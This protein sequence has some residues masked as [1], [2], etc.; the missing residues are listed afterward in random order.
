[1]LLKRVK[2]RIKEFCTNPYS[3]IFTVML[4]LLLFLIVVPLW[5]ILKE[6]LELS[7][8]DAKREGLE[9]GTLSFYY[10]KKLFCSVISQKM[11][12]QPL[13]HSLVIAICVSVISITIG[14]VAAWLMVRTDLPFK[15]FF[16][17]AI[18]VPY[19][20]PA[21]CKA[22]AWIAV[23]KN[24]RIGGAAGFLSYLGFQV[25]DW[26]AYGPVVMTI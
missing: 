1:M 23:F 18:I 16:T 26:L 17:L 5:E 11:L 10:W 3:V 7:V 22:M 24:P 12:Y 8:S 25:P 20:L 13:I 2:N 19:M 6:S 14:A 15:R 4:V 9:A 21:W